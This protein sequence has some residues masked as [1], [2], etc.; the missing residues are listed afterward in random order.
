[1]PNYDY[2][3][4]KCGQITE[5]FHKMSETPEIKCPKC[6]GNSKKMIGGGAGIHFKGSGF[7]VNDYK[8]SG[9]EN[10]SSSNPGCSGCPAGA[11]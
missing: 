8:K 9:C 7:Y 2:Q 11:K 6:R 10:Q 3:C 5:V 4:E 1:M